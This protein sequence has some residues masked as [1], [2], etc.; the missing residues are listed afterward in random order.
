MRVAELTG[1]RRRHTSLR[2]AGIARRSSPVRMRLPPR[3]LGLRHAGGGRGALSPGA[4]RALGS[5]ARRGLGY[6]WL[7]LGANGG[8]PPSAEIWASGFE[9][10]NLQAGLDFA[11]GTRVHIGPFASLTTAVYSWNDSLPSSNTFGG[12]ALHAWSSSA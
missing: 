2:G 5:L 10:V 12:P 1:F 11:V 3:L 7:H 8:V 4:R 6:E 9:L